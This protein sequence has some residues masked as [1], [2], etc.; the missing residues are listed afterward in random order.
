MRSCG[1]DER[2]GPVAGSQLPPP[3]WY[4]DPW[5]LYAWRWWDGTR[6]TSHVSPGPLPSRPAGRAGTETGAGGHPSGIA[7]RDRS[8]H[9]PGAVRAG[10][11]AFAGAAAG[12]LLSG[13]VGVVWGLAG[14]SPGGIGVL[15]IGEGALW[16]GLAGSCVVASRLKGTGRLSDDFGLRT[17]GWIDLA[18]GAGGAL[19]GLLVVAVVSS[20]FRA[21][22]PR[23][24]GS[25][26][27]SFSGFHSPLALALVGLV[28]CVGAPVVE[29]MFFRGLVQGTLTARYGPGVA[30]PLQAI[31]FGLGHADPSQGVATVSV[32]VAI[33]S[34]GV[35]LGVIRERTGRLGP[36]I[37][38][39]SLFNLVAF[40]G[41]VAGVA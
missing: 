6:W 41:I 24:L 8:P 5:R 13:L 2:Q 20:V 9:T 27:S 30:V 14:G 3:A 31:L 19:A 12:L 21:I 22:G 38:T 7:G 36:T 18:I 37:V 17:K 1:V 10:G 11:I 15:V 40:L 16:T 35:I 23:Y 39:H 25:N 28:L 29:E 26:T 32:I 4:P 34:L 33:A